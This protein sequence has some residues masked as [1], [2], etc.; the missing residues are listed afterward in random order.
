MN[1]DAIVY[2]NTGIRAFF[3]TKFVIPSEV[4]D[5]DGFNA[6][7]FFIILQTLSP[8]FLLNLGDPAAAL[9]ER[10]NTFTSFETGIFILDW[11]YSESNSVEN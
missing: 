2:N 4:E 11:E 3:I 5:V 9:S 10:I 8:L 7:D 6:V 1:S